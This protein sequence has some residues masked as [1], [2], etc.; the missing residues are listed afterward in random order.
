MLA[1]DLDADGDEDRAADDLDFALDEMAE[2]FAEGHGF[3]VRRATSHMAK[4][5]TGTEAI[6]AP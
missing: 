6:K 5:T 4:T 1:D 2:A 3:L